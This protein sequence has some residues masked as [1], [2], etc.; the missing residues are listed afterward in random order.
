MFAVMTTLYHSINVLFV[1]LTPGIPN[2]PSL[3]TMTFY[4]KSITILW[5]VEK[6]ELRPIEEYNITIESIQV[7]SPS[8]S[9]DR[10]PRGTTTTRVNRQISQESRIKARQITVTNVDC[11]SN[12][13]GID[14]CEHT[15]EE[16]VMS[17]VAYNVKLCAGN[18]FKSVCDESGF[19]IPV[20]VTSTTIKRKKQLRQKIISNVFFFLGGGG[21]STVV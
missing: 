17:G 14:Y 8:S 21:R 1:L 4:E 10:K 18:E 16:D 19:A 9:S 15:V 3:G 7:G 6:D 2:Q 11:K 20:I 5:T 12:A 13:S